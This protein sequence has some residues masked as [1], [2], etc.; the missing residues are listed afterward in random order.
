MTASTDISEPICAPRSCRSR[1][2]CR[3]SPKAGQMLGRALSDEKNLDVSCC[4]QT[5]LQSS[6]FAE[7]GGVTRTH[8][9]THTQKDVTAELPDRIYPTQRTDARWWGCKSKS[10]AELK[11]VPQK[12]LFSAE[13]GFLPAFKRLPLRGDLREKTLC[14][15]AKQWA[16]KGFFGNAKG[17]SCSASPGAEGADTKWPC[18]IPAARLRAFKKDFVS[19]VLQTEHWHKANY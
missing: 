16:G 9:W 14:A 18:C 1:A 2:D 8:I 19:S 17:N 4:V 12:A 7:A 15:Y 6:H 11:G 10:A 3:A 5:Y 13:V